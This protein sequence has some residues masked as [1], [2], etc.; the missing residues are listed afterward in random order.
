[1]SNQIDRYCPTKCATLSDVDYQKVRE[2]AES[3]R[4]ELVRRQ[5]ELRDQSTQELMRIAAELKGLEH[6]LAAID[7]ASGRR[8]PPAPP[9]PGLTDHI[10]KLLRETQV[11]LTASQIRDAC[12]AAGVRASSSRSL[13]MSV[14]TVLK[15]HRADIRTV[16]RDGALAYFPRPGFRNFPSGRDM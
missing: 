4:Q 5:A 10:R 14:Y 3:R 13:L 9:V 16:K 11:P 7:I 2:E 8:S 15:R 1:M 6:M 12:A